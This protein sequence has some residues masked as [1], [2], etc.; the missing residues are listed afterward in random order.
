MYPW[1]HQWLDIS[2][3]MPL[4]SSL[5]YLIAWICALNNRIWNHYIFKRTEISS[6]STFNCPNEIRIKLN[7]FC[8][9][10][11]S[12]EV[13]KKRF[14][15]ICWAFSRQNKT[16]SIV[17]FFHQPAVSLVFFSNVQDT[18]MDGM[19]LCLPT[20]MLETSKLLGMNV[21]E[22]KIPQRVLNPFYI[23]LSNFLSLLLLESLL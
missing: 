22:P 21:H 3:K 10:I 7:S 19:A 12:N 14:D 16:I 15:C 4:D 9:V 13:T 2:I 1:F 18:S 20:I 6:W 23:R 17:C 5:E 8:N 11:Y